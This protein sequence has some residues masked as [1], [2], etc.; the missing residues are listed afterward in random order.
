MK[1]HW[2]LRL[3]PNIGYGA[4]GR[5]YVGALRVEIVGVVLTGITM[6]LTASLL[7]ITIVT[8]A[9]NS[10]TTRERNLEEVRR[11]GAISESNQALLLRIESLSQESQRQVERVLHETRSVEAKILTTFRCV[12]RYRPSERTTENINGCFK[13]LP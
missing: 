1:P 10:T 12:L 3:L 5:F 7:G 6:L 8:V 2:L 11:A 4:D 9:S 13:G